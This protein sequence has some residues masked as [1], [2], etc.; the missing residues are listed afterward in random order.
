LSPEIGFGPPTVC[1]FRGA[2][3]PGLAPCFFGSGITS[4][5]DMSLHR[6]GLPAA[7]PSQGAQQVADK[8]DAPPSAA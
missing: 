1:A 8:P 6:S 4:L 3:L 7:V 5:R 2:R